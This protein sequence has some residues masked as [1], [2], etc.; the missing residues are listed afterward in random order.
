V[1]EMQ[2]RKWTVSKS[3]LNPAAPVTWKMQ[4]KFYINKG[5]QNNGKMFPGKK[6]YESNRFRKEEGTSRN[7]FIECGKKWF[8]SSYLWN[9]CTCKFSCTALL[10]FRSTEL[11]VLSINVMNRI[12]NCY[13]LLNW[14][15][16]PWWLLSTLA[17]TCF[18]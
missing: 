5:S 16:K 3:Y 1:L 7:T 12:D 8:T 17:V 18:C 10:F 13:N 14:I 2:F 11:L 4:Y 9:F 6:T 15:N